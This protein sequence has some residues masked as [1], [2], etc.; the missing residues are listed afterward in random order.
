MTADEGRACGCPRMKMK[1]LFRLRWRCRVNRR[2]RAGV[3]GEKKSS[4]IN[5][6]DTPPLMYAISTFDLTPVY[7]VF[8]LRFYRDFLSDP[9]GEAHRW[10]ATWKKWQIQMCMRSVWTLKGGQWWNCERWLAYRP[11]KNASSGSRWSAIYSSSSEILYYR[12]SKTLTL[13]VWALSGFSGSGT[14]SMV[15]P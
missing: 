10:E 12:I 5:N 9:S 15:I 3:N 13:T 11:P 4:T 2:E 14:Y 1:N 8:F 6:R 7:S